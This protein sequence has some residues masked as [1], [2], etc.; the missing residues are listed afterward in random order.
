MNPPC[1]TRLDRFR[2]AGPITAATILGDALEVRRYHLQHV[3]AARL[4][5]SFIMRNTLGASV[6]VVGTATTAW[7]NASRC[8]RL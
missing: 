8:S 2:G 1:L 6:R 4:L 3:F 7:F 5:P